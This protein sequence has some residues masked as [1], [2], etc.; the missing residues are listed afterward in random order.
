MIEDKEI[1]TS[2]EVKELKAQLK[3]KAVEICDEVSPSNSLLFTILRGL[4]SILPKRRKVEVLNEVPNHQ[5]SA[6]LIL[7]RLAR[8]VVQRNQ[9]R[10]ERLRKRLL[11]RRSSILIPT[12]RSRQGHLNKSPPNRQLGRFHPRR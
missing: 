5:K 10:I 7:L 11:L 3:A 2:E 8:R 9:K 12:L 1:F 6:R 4:R